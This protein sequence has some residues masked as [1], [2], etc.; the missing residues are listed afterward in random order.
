VPCGCAEPR[1]CNGVDRAR[2]HA[3]LL[4]ASDEHGNHCDP[5]S[6]DERSH[7]LRASEFVPRQAPCVG[8][9]GHVAAPTERLNGIDMDPYTGAPRHLQQA[10]EGLNDAR[11]G[12]H[13]LQR[14]EPDVAFGEGPLDVV[15]IHDAVGAHAGPVKARAPFLLERLG[16]TGDRRVLEAARDQRAASAGE[17]GPKGQV[18]C[19]RP[20]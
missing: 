11:L 15:E 14:H 16:H 9:G 17:R 6:H 8:S 19:L 18:V 20:S 10:P 1:R 5:R 2:P 13:G 3:A 7:R 4:T 12:V